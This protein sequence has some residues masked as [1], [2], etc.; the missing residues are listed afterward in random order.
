MCLA[1]KCGEYDLR[2]HCKQRCRMLG[3]AEVCRPIALLV[4]VL[5][6]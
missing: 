6:V 5:D 2:Q 4:I 1:T 3:R